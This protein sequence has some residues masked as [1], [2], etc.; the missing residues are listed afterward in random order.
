MLACALEWIEPATHVV[1]Y[2]GKSFDVPLLIARYRLARHSDP[3][4][5]KG[6]I[7]LLHLTRRVYGHGWN[8]C[9]LQTADQRLLGLI[10]GSDFPSH[11]IPQAW[12][13]FI[14]GGMAEPLG[15]I[16][17]HNQ[18]DVL[19]LAALLGLLAKGLY[20]TRS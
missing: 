8:D 10:Q 6:H 7:D 3:F 5:D 12:E 19:S 1:S 13:N 15:A 9:R 2:N 18:C 14:R 4:A 11:A 16:S 17:E 20:R